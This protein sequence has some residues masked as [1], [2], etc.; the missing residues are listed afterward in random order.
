MALNS[1]VLFDWLVLIISGNLS[2]DRLKQK[3]NKKLLINSP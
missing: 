3:R 1:M 2:R